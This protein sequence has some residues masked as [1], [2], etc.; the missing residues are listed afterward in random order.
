MHLFYDELIP[1]LMPVGTQST[2]LILFCWSIWLT[3]LM[4]LWWCRSRPL[5]MRVAAMYLGFCLPTSMVKLRSVNAYLVIWGTDTSWYLPENY[6]PKLLKEDAI[7]LI[8]G[9]GIRLVNS[10]RRLYPNSHTNLPL[11]PPAMRL[12]AVC[13]IMLLILLKLELSMSNC[14]A[15]M[16]YMHSLLNGITI[17]ECY[18]NSLQASTALYVY[19]IVSEYLAEG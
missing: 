11:P 12:D 7:N 15:N 9:Y 1:I 19:T 10:Y 4:A 16:L 5:Y 17:D 6:L 18:N 3:A 13:A 8:L 2:N 14:S